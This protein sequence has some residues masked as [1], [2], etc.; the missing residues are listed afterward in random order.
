M[1]DKIFASGAIFKV[2]DTQYGEM[3][4]L[5]IKTDEFKDFLDTYDKNGWVNLNM[6][7]SK[8]WNKPYLELDTWEPKGEKKQETKEETKEEISINDL[9]FN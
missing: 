6:K 1:S 8:D 7:R 3:I 5:S 9:P 2:Q 4:K